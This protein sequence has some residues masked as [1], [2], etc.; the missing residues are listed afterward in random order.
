VAAK[1]A[2][3][4]DLSKPTGPASTEPSTAPGVAKAT[5]AAAPAASTQPVETEATAEAEFERAEAEYADANKQP[6]DQQ[7]IAKLIGEYEPLV[8]SDKLTNTLHRIAE[9][10]LATLKLRD[11]AAGELAKVKAQQEEMEKRQVAL[12][13]EGKELEERLQTQGVQIY[14]AVGELQMSSLQLNAKTLY[15]LTDPANGRTVCYIRT[16]DPK[17]VTYLGKFIGVKGE[18]STDPQLSLKVV[19]PKDVANVDATKVN[20]GVS[21]TIVP[22]SMVAADDASAAAH[23]ETT[24]Q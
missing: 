18:L 17:F 7:P 13:A 8:A 22:P 6:L 3:S 1:E 5:P 15:R 16:D 21:A 14:T 19:S 4:P 24:R 9:S 12:K 11:K 10:R 20:R 23:V 2:S